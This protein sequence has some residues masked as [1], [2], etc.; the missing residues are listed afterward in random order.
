MPSTDSAVMPYT[1]S[2]V[3]TLTGLASN[4]HSGRTEIHVSY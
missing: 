4:G 2:E 1:V 3:S